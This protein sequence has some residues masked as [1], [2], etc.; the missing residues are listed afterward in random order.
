MASEMCRACK[1]ASRINIAS[2]LTFR[3]AC[4]RLV[5][6]LSPHQAD[7]SRV[8]C[9]EPVPV[10]IEVWVLYR[11]AQPRHVHIQ[12]TL[13]FCGVAR[14][15]AAGALMNP[16]HTHLWTQIPTGVL[17]EQA[18]SDVLQ[19]LKYVFF[20]VCVCVLCELLCS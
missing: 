1:Y 19:V 16:S 7:P 17:L 3:Q 6:F 14:K 4:G 10:L 8:L 11:E 18:Q 12:M 20:F 9:R 13:H 5:S 2:L 15:S